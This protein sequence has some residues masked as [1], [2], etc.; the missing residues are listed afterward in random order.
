V[1]WGIALKAGWHFGFFVPSVFWLG[2][3]GGV[4]VGVQQWLVLRRHI[5][6][7]IIWIPAFIASSCIG[8]WAGE[9]AGSA[10]YNHTSN[11]NM[12]YVIGGACVGAAVGLLSSLPLV[13]LLTRRA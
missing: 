4:F 2:C 5:E 8:T 9:V 3:G 11:E 12:A 13:W 7:A 6:R 10:Y 1:G